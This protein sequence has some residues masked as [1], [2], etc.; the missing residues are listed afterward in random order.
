MGQLLNLLWMAGVP[1]AAVLFARG[2]FS[3]FTCGDGGDISDQALSCF[4]GV[5][6]SLFWP[7]VIPLA[8]VWWFAFGREAKAQP[9]RERIP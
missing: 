8:A 2:F 7:A 6:G 4:V 9:E 5:L 3:W 1:F